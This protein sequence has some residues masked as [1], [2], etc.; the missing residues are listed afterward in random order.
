MSSFFQKYQKYK[1]K[2]LGGRRKLKRENEFVK[3]MDQRSIIVFGENYSAEYTKEGAGDPRVTFF[4]KIV[5]GLPRD[6][7][8]LYV[9]SILQ[10]YDE[11][12][13]RNVFL[14]LFVI[15]FHSRD[16]RGG[17][18]ERDIFYEMMIELY[19][20]YPEIILELLALVPYYGYYK[21]YFRMMEMVGHVHNSF[22]ARIYELVAGQLNLD[23]AAL[24]RAKEGVPK[25]SLLA[26]YIPKEHKYFD[27]VY[28]FVEHI[29]KILYPEVKDMNEQKRLYRLQVSALNKA[30]GTAEVLMS[31]R[32]F[33]EI[34]F[35]KLASKATFKYRKAF[36]NI[37][38]DKNTER[39]I[40]EDRKKARDNFLKAIR[41][42]KIS[43]KQLEIY[44]IAKIV[45]EDM[46]QKI[47]KEEVSLFQVQWDKI[48]EN[49]LKQLGTEI[50]LA[51]LLPIADV[52]GSMFGMPM[53][54]SVSLSLLLSEISKTFADRIVTFSETPEWIKLDR[55]ADVVTKMRQVFA[56]PFGLNTNFEAV[57]DMIID[58]VRSKKLEEK[59]IP[60]LIVFS[61]MQFDLAATPER[62]KTHHQIIVEKFQNVGIEISGKP[63]KIPR[64]IYWNLRADTI[65][66]PVQANTP[67]VE[68]ISGFS[69]NLLKHILGGNISKGFKIITP[70]ETLRNILDDDRYAIIREITNAEIK[71]LKNVTP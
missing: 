22:T 52:S 21:D 53:Y 55:N 41:D 44:E 7:I 8:N 27:Q 56:A 48:R 57:Y 26:K 65:G 61:D 71:K 60:D 70:Y 12:G 5:R 28:R 47:T 50:D 18:G 62:Y 59:D 49:L 23:T 64:I 69:P 13:D 19:E 16:I 30:L 17:K 68:M 66:F 9:K 32:K 24:D 46:D 35:S 6:Q 45:K 43:G 34:N 29:S 1:S 37:G 20:N 2:Y 38:V 67:N 15:M 39:S 25:I 10:L 3:E 54:V 36:L 14:D 33:A 4:F 63:Y 42:K 31:A 51:N 11:T 58:V 40:E